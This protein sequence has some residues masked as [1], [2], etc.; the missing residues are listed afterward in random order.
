MLGPVAG[1]PAEWRLSLG[2]RGKGNGGNLWALLA[3]ENCWRKEILADP[4]GWKPL[5]CSFRLWGG[6]DRDWGLKSLGREPVLPSL[7][8]SW[9]C[10]E[11]EMSKKM[12]QLSFKT[13][14]QFTLLRTASPT[15]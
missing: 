13:P 12:C 3:R 1:T 11:L 6:G 4:E 7:G 14:S 9:N 15:L 8:P 10:G 5:A 2:D